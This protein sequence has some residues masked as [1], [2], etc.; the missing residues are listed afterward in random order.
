MYGGSVGSA[1]FGFGGLSPF[2]PSVVKYQKL[3]PIP[4]LPDARQG[5][6]VW[7]SV[8]G[9]TSSVSLCLYS[10]GVM[11]P[12]ALPDVCSRHYA[13]KTDSVGVGN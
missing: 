5:S 13:N 7:R 11:D 2:A 12:I 1:V 3:A 4:W 6:A 9:I 10:R 8:A